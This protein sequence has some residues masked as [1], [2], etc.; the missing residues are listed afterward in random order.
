MSTIE[1]D[2]K[3]REQETE[4]LIQRYM[5]SLSERDI[6]SWMDLWDEDCVL[7]FPFAPQE[8]VSQIEGKAALR[9]YIQAVLKD[10]EIA[11][12]TRQKVYLTLE[13]EVFIAEIAVEGRIISTGRTYNAAYVWIMRTKD[14]KLL[15]V[16]DYW[17][18]MAM[19]EARREGNR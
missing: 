17:N 12:I 11:R 15:H 3:G 19:M 16:R 4:T 1:A 14:G 18:P 8:R 7:E 2:N 6:E 13:P 5:Q 10:A 9:P